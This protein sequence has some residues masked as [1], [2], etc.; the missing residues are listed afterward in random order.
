V[1]KRWIFALRD[2]QTGSDSFV[3][4]D[5]Y[6]VKKGDRR[7]AA[8]DRTYDTQAQAICAMKEFAAYPKPPLPDYT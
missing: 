4:D 8:D 1:D 5:R 6:E 7:S 3:G 2:N